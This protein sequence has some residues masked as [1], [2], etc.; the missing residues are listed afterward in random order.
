MYRQGHFV[1]IA[2]DSIEQEWKLA[3]F[4]E[5]YWKHMYKFTSW[6][7]TDLGEIIWLFPILLFHLIE[8]QMKFIY[9]IIR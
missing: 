3:L 5:L 1:F 6:L 8:N 2:E 7:N 9:V 4:W